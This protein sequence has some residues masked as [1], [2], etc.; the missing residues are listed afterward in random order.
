M[1]ACINSSHLQNTGSVL[2]SAGNCGIFC[3]LRGGG[4]GGGGEGPEGVSRGRKE[5]RGGKEGGSTR[6]TC[7][8]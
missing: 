2:L 5:G 6:L 7:T 3:K 1:S 8:G 4:G